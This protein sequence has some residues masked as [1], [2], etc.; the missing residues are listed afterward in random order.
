MTV[1]PSFVRFVVV[2]GLSV[3]VNLGAR[4][5]FSRVVP[6]EAAV[7]LSHAVGMV[8]AWALTRVFVFGAS[9]T[10]A[11]RELARFAAVN[12]VSAAITWVVAVSLLRLVFPAVGW[13]FEPGIVAHVA[14][15]AAASVASFVGHRDFSFR[16]TVPPAG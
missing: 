6:Y 8:T 7:L 3:P 9:E 5:V 14:G 12:V 2:A 4:V 13:T 15:L 10:S 1:T 16:R 11:G